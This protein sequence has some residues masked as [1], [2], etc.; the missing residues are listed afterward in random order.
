MTG[1]LWSRVALKPQAL[2]PRSRS[3]IRHSFF[4][5]AGLLLLIVWAFALWYV[6]TDHM[7][8]VDFASEQIRSV[9]DSL[10]VQMEAMLVD[11]LGSAESALADLPRSGS[12]AMQPP[13]L[14]VAQLR[15]EVTGS[16][17]RALFI[18]DALRTIVA[19]KNVADESLGI[20]EW[21]PRPPQAG[22]TVVALPIADPSRPNRR[23]I[24][25]A[26]GLAD[27]SKGAAWMGMWFD[28]EE[29]LV[30]Y[31]AIAIDRG[32]ISI[33]S[34]EGW[35]LAGTSLP[36]RP[37]PP[38]T[39]LGESEVF[40][41]ISK[42]P[43]GKAQIIDGV[44]VI[45]NKRKLFAAAKISPDVPV[46][47][48]V[49]R[50]YD[51]IIAPWKRNTM[52]VVWLTL[53]LSTLLIV[54]TA[55]L[56]RF[57][58][59]INRRESQ[60]QKLF[61]SSLASTLLLREGRIVEKNSQA[62]RTFQVPEQQTLFGKRFEEISADVQPDG[63]RSE[64][65]L[66]QHYE[67]LRRAGG[68]VFQWTFLR[69]ASGEPFEAEVHMSTI[70]VADE[71][72]TLVMVR[73]I[74]E[75]EAAK[76]ALKQINLQLESRVAQ[77]TAELQAANSQLRSTNRALEEF[78]GAASHD[79]RSPLGIISGQAGLLELTL[80]DALGDPGKRR[81]ARIQQAVIRA[82]DV[83]EGLLSLASITRQ[84]L[85]A[86]QVDLSAVAQDVIDE[87]REMDA[88]HETDIFIQPD[89]WV[90]ADR[91][92]MISLIS[93]LIGNAWKYSSKRPTIWIRFDRTE[94]NGRSVY[95]VA[96][97][98]TGFDMDHAATLFQAFRRLHPREEFSGVGLGLATV[99]R[100]VSRYGGE[101]WAQAEPDAGAKF[102]FTLPDAQLAE[103]RICVGDP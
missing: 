30:R 64:Q 77:R 57:L 17:I 18:G 7:R 73:D 37:A 45:D 70:Q 35:V 94:E 76:R 43:G 66:Q 88:G 80:G 81:I 58:D 86:E 33:Q 31:Q 90:Y 29:L 95:C 25:L 75:Q 63:V 99:H 74:S 46:V 32:A 96:D 40:R 68:A 38:P 65:A 28:V 24:P 61:E 6:R 84:E 103:P 72:V 12:I 36:G 13:E 9:A 89:M 47:L 87:L 44:S 85:Q 41:A 48:V 42:L 56:Y 39:H 67:T 83:I 4:V 60:F 52:T 82:S 15:G 59:E 50:E 102:F 8:T 93:N 49:S 19:G 20:P 5:Y 21:L 71:A 79:L 27:P 2:N 3:T 34:A 92:L 55:L 69:T 22:E 98:G 26:R 10:M 51:A 23:V 54:M 53:G 78:T 62:R 11:G 16:Y 101:I 100:I 91:R 14:V 97:R 1:S